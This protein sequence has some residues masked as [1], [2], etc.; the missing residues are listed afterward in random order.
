MDLAPAD[1]DARPG[2][3]AI[4]D[5]GEPSP[6]ISTAHGPGPFGAIKPDLLANG[7]R[8]DVR[9]IAAGD[10]LRLRVVRETGR[11][12][13]FVAAGRAGRVMSNGAGLL[14]GGLHMRTRIQR[15]ARFVV[16]FRVE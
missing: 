8:H 11:S 7:G 3:A 2:E 12:G 4:Q 10:N 6:A 5:D 16:C 14:V 13:V 15:P 1:W 9:P